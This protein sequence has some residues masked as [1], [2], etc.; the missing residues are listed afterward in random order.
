[1][2]SPVSYELVDEIGVVTIDNPPVNALSHAVRQG[3]HDAIEAAQADAS[4]A[5]LVLCAGRTFIAGADIREFGQPPQE[6]HLPDLCAEIENSS[7]L[8]VAALHGTAL[9]GGFEVALS[10]H[11]RCAVQTAK[12]GLPEVKLGLLPG[13]GG[14]QRTPRLAGAMAA[15]DLITSGN[16]V[17]A[18][19][20]ASL[21]LIDHLVDGDLRDAA[22]EWCRH[23]VAKKASRRKTSELRVESVSD[24]VLA[25]YR[26]RLA[27][28]ARGQ[29]APQKIIECIEAAMTQPF[30][31]GMVTER[32]KFIECMQSP[33]SAAMRHMF[34]A[35]REAA[36]VRD[37]A[38]DTAL[39]SI[40][41]VGVIGAGT[42]GGGIAM[43]FA[44]AGMQV[45]LL[46]V[47][48]EALSNGLQT[49]DRNYMGG[50]KRG[51]LTEAEALERRGRITGTTNY[52]TLAD[53]DLVVE[54]VFESLDLKQDIFA[55]LDAV[56]KQGAILATNTSYQDVNRIAAATRRPED[57]IGLHFFSPA[58]I[59]KL[60]EVVR[61]DETAD[62][63]LATCMALAKK[64]RKT[65]VV[66]GVCYGFIGNRMLGH[67]G[68][69]A[70][71][72]V[73]EGASPETVDTAME[74]WGMAMGPLAVFD[75][76]GLDVG[77]KARQGLP[78][79]KRGDPRASRVADVLVEMGRCGQKTGA[80]F[81]R[82]DPDTRKRSNDP[83]V[84][85]L[86][87]HEAASLDVER[88]EI[89]SSE[90]VDRLIFA[91]INEGMRI[92]DEGIAQ[93]PGDIDV[94]YVYGY[95]FPAFRG[96][97]MHYADTVSLDHVLARVQEFQQRFGS[98]NWTPAP[99]LERLV[100][101]KTTLADWAKSQIGK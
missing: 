76:A 87:E 70:Q 94:V 99:L 37:L 63:V 78:K 77:Y 18:E 43:N 98:D 68:R 27:R 69:E 60:L 8:V 81:Y 34:F 65:P 19:R 97:P 84:D 53:A 44:N 41:Q 13:A 46:E 1:M 6:P 21:G 73:I 67:Y 95:G 11:Y 101:E 62:E 32:K 82:Y 2:T 14:T 50:I 92:L 80:G 66:S 7:K 74:Q 71:L 28:R 16:P 57:V 22:L 64:I 86:I 47:S 42:M 17:D 39:R 88:R 9:G 3:I 75:L 30:P 45:T 96:G 56:C 20:A 31:D 58:H 35:E 25:D 4:K 83:E 89:D 26:A 33:Q 100:A 23:L 90:I 72:C 59:M 24:G 10:C 12:V 49:I 93:R 79:E 5:V 15:L 51:K 91:L 52:A 48:D 85:A 54:A 61:A 38:A 55:E 29:V 40:E 36:R